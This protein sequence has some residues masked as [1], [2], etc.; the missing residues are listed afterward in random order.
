MYGNHNK[1]TLKREVLKGPGRASDPKLGR[2]RT[3]LFAGPSTLSREDSWKLGF[4][5]YMVDLNPRP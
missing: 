2:T 1:G 3:G 4:R 5:D